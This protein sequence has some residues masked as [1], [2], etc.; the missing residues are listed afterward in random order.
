[1]LVKKL[2]IIA[3]TVFTLAAPLFIWQQ[4]PNVETAQS[5]CPFKMATGLP[6]PGCGITKSFISI[7][8]GNWWKSLSYHIFG[9]LA[10]VL[11][12]IVIFV[13]SIELFTGKKYFRWLVYNKKLAWVLAITLMIY[14][15]VRLILFLSSHSFDQIL[16]ESIW[17]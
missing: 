8:Q 4:N 3:L 5:L 6:C 12:F 7:Y 16:Q 11:S 17:K 2:I 10:F 15:F 9:P 14:H 1:M 13:L